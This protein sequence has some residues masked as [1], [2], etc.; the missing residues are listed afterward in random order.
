MKIINQSHFYALAMKCLKMELGKS[1]YIRK[2]KIDVSL[3]REV[4]DSHSENYRI[5]LK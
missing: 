3:A 2:S 4:Q 5:L 1:T